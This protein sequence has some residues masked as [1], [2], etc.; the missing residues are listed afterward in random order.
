MK[1]PSARVPLRGF[2]LIELVVTLA[3]VAVAAAVIIPEMRGTRDAA[4]LR[5]IGR[6]LMSAASLAYSQA[7]VRNQV[8]RLTLDPATGRFAI[9]RQINSGPRNRRGGGS[10]SFTVA[11]DLPGGGRGTVDSG[12][13]VEFRPT[14][15]G[16]DAAAEATTVPGRTAVGPPALVFHPDGTADAAEVSLRDA[17]G[18]RLLFRLNPVTARLQA[19]ELT[20]P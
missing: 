19:V 16:E 3:I 5:A 17:A 14:G 9:E 20:R 12:V 8:H 4:V 2:T 7:V 15:L 13:R 6:R 18:F 1:H 11:A 10:G